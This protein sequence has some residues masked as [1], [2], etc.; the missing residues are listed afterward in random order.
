MMTDTKTQMQSR[1]DDGMAAL[2]IRFRQGLPAR[3]RELRLQ[4]EPGINPQGLADAAHR[5]AGAAGLFGAEDVLSS[6]R[7]LERMLRRMDRG[8]VVCLTHVRAHLEKL[9]V[10]L[11]DRSAPPVSDI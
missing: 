7:D 11:Q 2:E 8:E 6:A 4:S 10:L 3:I 1:I 5:L 9:L